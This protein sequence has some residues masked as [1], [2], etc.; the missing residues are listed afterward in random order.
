[1]QESK[2]DRGESLQRERAGNQQP[3]GTGSHAVHRQ[4]AE[5]DP[6]D[7]KAKGIT[8]RRKSED[9]RA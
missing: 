8:G 7:T 1:M 5:R 6:K 3:A 2:R 9:R 4:E